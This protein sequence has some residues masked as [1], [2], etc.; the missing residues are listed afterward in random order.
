MAQ[1]S[2][3]GD[4]SKGWSIAQCTR[5]AVSDEKRSRQYDRRQQLILCQHVF[6]TPFHSPVSTLPQVQSGNLP[7]T[8][9]C[10]TSEDLHRRGCNDLQTFTPLQADS[11]FT[12]DLQHRCLHRSLGLYN[13]LTQ[14]S[15][16]ERE[17]RYHTWCKTL[18]GDFGVLALC[19]EDTGYTEYSRETMENRPA[20]RSSNDPGAYG[21]QIWALRFGRSAI[22]KVG[23]HVSCTDTATVAPGPHVEPEPLERRH[24]RP[25]GPPGRQ[26]RVDTQRPVIWPSCSRTP[27]SNSR[28]TTTTPAKQIRI[29]AGARRA[30]EP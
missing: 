26:P 9:T 5:Y 1:E 28:P 15:G 25:R 6:P 19:T 14:P 12:A 22:T 17:K 18:G 30:L 29:I 27:S 8:S 23:N 20:G 24:E 21:L 13:T 11:W 16:E 3:K 4:G 2:A 7:F 10:L